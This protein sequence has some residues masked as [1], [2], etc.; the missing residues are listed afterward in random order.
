[1]DAAA[2]EGFFES[3]LNHLGLTYQRHVPVRGDKNVDFR[4]EGDPAILCDV[5]EV[6]ASAIG[7]PDIDAYSH[8]REDLAELRKKFGPC[9]PRI[10]V[11]LV[12][13]N[14]SARLFTGFSIARAML[15]DVGAEIS[16]NGRGEFHHLPRGNAAMTRSHHTVLSGILLFDCGIKGNHALFR[17]PYATHPVPDHWFPAVRRVIVDR[18]AT[19]EHLKALANITFWSCDEQASQSG[20]LPK[21]AK[22]RMP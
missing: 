2:S 21:E 8:I 20:L 4:I 15:G 16:P 1:M 3:Y 17:N 7:S 10:P 6:R 14:F 12:T 19:E 11:L 13:V 5:K 22:R 18:D 9:R